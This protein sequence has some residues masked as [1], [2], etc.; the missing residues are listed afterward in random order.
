VRRIL[1]TPELLQDMQLQCSKYARPDAAKR[2]A[3]RI[4]AALDKLAD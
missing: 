3:D 1:S 2:I 4:A